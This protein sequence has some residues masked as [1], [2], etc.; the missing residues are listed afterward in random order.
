MWAKATESD[1][2][3]LDRLLAALQN[4]RPEARDIARDMLADERIPA[5]QRQYAL[6][7]LAKFKNPADDELIQKCAERFV[8]AGHSVFPGSR[9]QV[10]AT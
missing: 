10:A 9:H 2:P 7:A 6:L 1:G 8:T 3:A 4:K 5:G